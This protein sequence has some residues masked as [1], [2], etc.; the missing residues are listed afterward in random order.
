MK[1]STTGHNAGKP[2]GDK[3]T[4]KRGATYRTFRDGLRVAL[5]TPGIILLASS[6]G[7]GALAN[8]AGMSLFNAVLMMGTFFALP[9]QVV[10]M[11]QLA[12]GG[13]ILAGAAAVALTGVR[14]VPMVVTILPWLR[15]D[16]PA[17][18]R[19]LLAT[20]TIAIT[21][22][23]EGHRILPS[24]PEN[25]RMQV[26]LGIGTGMMLTTLV[27]TTAGFELAGLVPPLLAGVLLFL[28]PV[29]FLLSLMAA[30]RLAMDWIAIVIGCFM[31]PLLYVLTP[32]FDLLL[33]GLIGGSFAY[34]AGKKIEAGRLAEEQDE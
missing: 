28:T 34:L 33:T 26:F 2:E 6:A 29:Y 8:D 16:R 24:V 13:S 7:F 23:L 20:H 14:L 15:D 3:S 31:G 5:S 19:R 21:A 27:G 17:L 12:R 18:W 1:E 25:L 22:W 9:A 11:D 32:G 10:M 4:G 30:A